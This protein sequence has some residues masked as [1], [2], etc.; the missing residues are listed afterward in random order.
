M[1]D[2]F[3]GQ[4]IGKAPKES[5]GKGVEYEGGRTEAKRETRVKEEGAC[6]YET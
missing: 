1:N 6:P 4:L 2:A 3:D 5:V